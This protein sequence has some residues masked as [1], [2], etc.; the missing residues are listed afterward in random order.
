MP[1]TLLRGATVVTMDPDHPRAEALAVDGDRIAAIGTRA[2]VEASV[3]GPV[4]HVD[5]VG[6]A[7]LPGFI[8]PHH[9]ASQVAFMSAATP[10][11]LR[12]GAS[13]S[14]LL[15]QVAA[16][17]R[18][19]ADAPWVRMHGYDHHK[20]REHRAPLRDE[21]DEVVP[22]RPLLL[23]AYS[24]HEGVLNSRAFD[25]LGWDRGSPDPPNGHIARGGNGRPAGEIAEGALYIA[26]AASRGVML[27]HTGDAFLDFLEAHCHRLLA[28]G[29]TRIGDAAVAPEFEAAYE[30]AATEERLPL[31]VHRMPV[32]SSILSPRLDGLPTGAGPPQAPIG[33]A[34][35]FLDGSDRCAIC[36]SAP[37][38]ARALGVVLGRIVTG[39]GLSAIRAAMRVLQPPRLAHG[40]HVCQGL[41]FWEREPLRQTVARAADRGFQVAQHAIGN[42]A[43]DLALDAIEHSDRKLAD[44]PGRPRIEH[45][46]IAD[47]RLAQRAA[48][49]G[50]IAVVHPY[51]VEDNGDT[52]RAYPLPAPL[53]MIPLATLR[54]AGVVL[55]GA[56]DFPVAGYDVMEAIGSAV[57]RRTASGVELDPGEALTVH[58]ALEA[59]TV[60]SAQALAVE[61]EVGSLRRGM[62]ADLVHLDADPLAVDPASLGDIAVQ[63]T[64][65]GGRKVA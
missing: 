54:D 14:E 61:D 50:A 16:E 63:G 62:R 21:L 5:L 13:I 26:D 4:H 51:W 7:L 49:L 40:L 65:V 37:Q 34:K 29:I 32:A 60:G 17:A 52:L 27:E 36:L 1:T 33:P 3:R 24:F 64:W 43:I 28:A 58:Q 35:L 2:E 46:A 22:D 18:R 56:S 44:R 30:R 12:E 39:G 9:H 53:R 57:L 10:V 11:S 15:D 38:A 31:A 8:D 48:A 6:G 20:L 23:I 19:D 41:R 45:F 42:A 25:E 47:A 59:Y 55:A